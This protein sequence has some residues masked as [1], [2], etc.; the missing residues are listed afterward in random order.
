METVLASKFISM[1]KYSL[2]A[3]LV[4]MSRN[5][6]AE[7]YVVYSAPQTVVMTT[8]AEPC[9]V[10]PRRP[11][12]VYHRPVKRYKCAYKRRYTCRTRCYTPC[13]RPSCAAVTVYYRMPACGNGC[14]S[15]GMIGESYN[16]VEDTT[17]YYSI[18][19]EPIY[20]YTDTYHHA[21]YNDR[22]WDMRTADDI[23]Y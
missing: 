13:Q 7:Y 3:L 1:G 4:L 14:R 23:Y 18:S 10:V 5:V 16:W 21:Y 22:N 17:G 9:C 2:I 6:Y 15:N 12:P 20:G 8:P 19:G 11:C